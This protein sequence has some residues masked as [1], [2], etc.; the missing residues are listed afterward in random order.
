VATDIKCVYSIEP[1]ELLPAMAR[2]TQ[3]EPAEVETLERGRQRTPL[4]S[5]PTL[6]G[7]FGL[8][9]A[10]AALET[11][12]KEHFPARKSRKA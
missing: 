4:G 7:I 9:A 8:T 5:L 11:L 10:N 3:E 2:A 1:G 6:T 12:L